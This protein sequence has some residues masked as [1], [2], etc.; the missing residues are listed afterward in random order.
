MHIGICARVC[1]RRWI[2]STGKT[3][4]FS[5]LHQPPLDAD[6]RPCAAFSQNSRGT[7]RAWTTV[8]CGRG[9]AAPRHDRRGSPAGSDEPPARALRLVHAFLRR[10]P[11]RHRPDAGLVPDPASPLFAVVAI[12][13]RVAARLPSCTRAR[14]FQP[15]ATSVSFVARGARTS[16]H[17]LLDC[18]VAGLRVNGPPVWSRARRLRARALYDLQPPALPSLRDTDPDRVSSATTQRAASF[19]AVD[20]VWAPTMTRLRCSASARGFGAAG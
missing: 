14:I 8:R 20:E 3:T 1:S 9:R 13:G 18:L 12:Y 5:L 10:D 17:Q 16:S 19:G 15:F 7:H 4:Y 11:R 6:S 2:R